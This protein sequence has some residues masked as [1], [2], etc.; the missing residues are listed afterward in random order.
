MKKRVKIFDTTLR[1]GEQSPGVNLN[2]QEKLEIARQLG[3]LQVDV[4]E[5]GFPI[6]SRGDFV[7]VREVANEVRGPVI[8]ALA[9]TN[10]EDIDAAWEAVKGAEKPQ[11]HVFIATSPIHMQYKLQKE[12]AQV[13]QDAVEM[14][15][16]ARKYCPLVEFS[17]EDGSRSH[18]EFLAS[19]FSGVIEAGATTINLPDTVGYSTPEEFSRLI[20]YLFTAVPALA[21][22]TF[23]VHCHN[24]LGLAVANSLAA[25][26]CGA[27]QIEGAINGIGERAGNTALEE[28]IMALTT[29]KDLYDYS[30]GVKT[31]EIYRTSRLVSS[32]TGMNIQANKAIVGANAFAH[33]AGIHQDGVIKE[34]TTYEIMDPAVIGLNKNRLVL[35]KHS[36]RSGL[37]NRLQELGYYLEGEELDRA[38]RRLKELSD[39]KKVISDRDLEA[40]V[41]DEQKRVEEVFTLEF[42]QVSSGNKIQP[43]AT[44]G[45]QVFNDVLQK[46][47][48]FGSGPVDAVYNTI[49]RMTGIHLTLKEYSIHAVTSGKDAL[50]EV[51]VRVEYQDKIFLGRGFSTDVIEASARA[52]IHALNKVIY[53][54]PSLRRDLQQRLGRAKT[55]MAEIN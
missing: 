10:R 24:D 14:V 32:L 40:I 50:G 29:R 36:G 16:Y 42:L 45:L 13:L 11:I 26:D 6:T 39:K 48:S 33:E 25:L 4:I 49:E 3:R 19:V 22:I 51:M 41:E 27:T 47:A 52:Y 2:L 20:Q 55:S 12:P 8:T 37:K 35:G 31:Q 30:L 7:A 38:Y 21:Q 34:R 46:E 1:D 5:A 15:S 9:R 44:L 18:P 54:E 23:S 17:A 28:V 43:T 53:D